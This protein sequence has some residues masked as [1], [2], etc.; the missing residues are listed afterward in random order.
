MCFNEEDFFIRLTYT[1][2]LKTLNLLV[3]KCLRAFSVVYSSYRDFKIFYKH[4]QAVF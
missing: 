2:L 1:M 4:P 3:K